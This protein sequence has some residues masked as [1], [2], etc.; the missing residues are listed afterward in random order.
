VT[1]VREALGAQRLAGELRRC[2]HAK[3]FRF[4]LENGDSQCD[5]CQRV[6]PAALSKRGRNARIRGNARELEI[7]KATGGEK[8]GHHGGPE[9]VRLG[10][11]NIQ[12]KV[13][14]GS[15]FPGWQWDEL[16]KLP[17]TGG[18]IPAL[19]VTDAPGPGIRRRS[20]VVL[21]LEDFTDLH[22]RITSEEAP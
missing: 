4:R 1:D 3:K 18:R 11:L 13:R 19:I 5:R 12:S 7:A 6:I 16:S 10:L 8:V 14:S 15:A 17:R 22:G 2:V 9:D 20:I 21:T